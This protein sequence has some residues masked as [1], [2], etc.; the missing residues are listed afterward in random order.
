MD[1]QD[2]GLVLTSRPHGES[3]AA[4]DVLTLQHGRHAGIVRG[5]QSRK[6]QPALQ[7]GTTLH[8]TWRARLEDHMG[9]FMIEPL[10][11]R[12]A[13]LSDR[14]ALAAL[15]AVTTL[16]HFA[17]PE[18]DPHPDLYHRS[19]ALIDRL[20]GTDDWL[21]DYLDWEVG[22]LDELGYGLDLGACAV[23]GTTE[24]LCYVSPK[25]GRAVSRAG[26]GDWASKLLPLPPCLMG[27]PP[28]DRAELL[29]A[30]ATTG[31]F[32]DHKLARD[33]GHT[34]LPPAR[35]RLIDLLA[36]GATT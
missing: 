13:L 25:S 22:L 27:F 8:L 35:Q 23:T 10:K 32:L 15:N 9:S 12:S 3:S 29:Q 7:P 28:G 26:A 36:R 2:E 1:W 33:L 14:L 16:I 17:L 19:Q 20:E 24:D 18:R 30:L 34:P 6:M 21:A 5:G 31:W 4:L 11:S